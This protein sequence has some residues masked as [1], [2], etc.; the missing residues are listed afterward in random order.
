MDAERTIQHLR[1]AIAAIE[2]GDSTTARL[3]IDHAVDQINDQNKKA[4][5]ECKGWGAPTGC[6]SCGIRCMGG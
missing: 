3:A 1:K 2:N 4:C 6:R 5:K